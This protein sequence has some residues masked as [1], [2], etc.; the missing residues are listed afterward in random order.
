MQTGKHTAIYVR[1]STAG[2]DYASPVPNLE[3]WEQAHADAVV[4]YWVK[5]TG[6]TMD[7]PGME[8]LTLALHS[9]LLERIVIWRLD[10][11][12]RTARGLCHL[13]DQLGRTP[14][15]SGFAA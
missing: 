13:F 14:G 15:R 11:L 10:R 3:K 7:R 2:Q 4:W 8:K 9:G 6:R 1:V 12:G 5:F